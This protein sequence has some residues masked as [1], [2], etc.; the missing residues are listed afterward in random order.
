[1]DTFRLDSALGLLVR[2][3]LHRQ[4]LPDG[5]FRWV[6]ETPLLVQLSVEVTNS[7]APPTFKASAGRSILIG[8]AVFDLL[9]SIVD[10]VTENY[11]RTYP[12]HRVAAYGSLGKMLSAWCFAARLDARELERATAML[13]SYV[14]SIKGLLNPVRR[15]D[16][17]GACPKCRQQF[18]R[19][20]GED[21]ATIRRNVITVAWESG[22]PKSMDCEVCGTLTRDPEEIES[23]ARRLV[24]TPE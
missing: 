13:E 23:Y 24:E 4:T 9:S 12:K 7:S 3:S 2:P 15:W 20:A 14:R 22:V 5:S 1:M 11:W 17:K 6:T 19:V 21:G 16:I 8:A 18:V 10:E